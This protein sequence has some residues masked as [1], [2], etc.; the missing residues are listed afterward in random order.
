MKKVVIYILLILGL[1]LMVYRA[2]AGLGAVTALSDYQPWGLVKAVNV[3]TGAALA[4]GSFVVAAMVYVF[5]LRQFRPLVRPA[6]L[7]GFI[8]HSFVLIA[9]LYDVGRPLDVWRILTNPQHH[10]ALMWTAWCEIVY[11]AAMAI[12][13]FSERGMLAKLKVPLVVFSAALAVVYQS[14]LGTLYLAS[15]DAISQL[16]YSD[17]LPA[18]FFLSAVAAG[19]GL[20]AVVSH[21]MELTDRRTLRTLSLLMGGTLV[22]YLMLRAGSL[23]MSGTFT[24][25][26][27]GCGKAQFFWFSAELVIGGAL[28]LVFIVAGLIRD[29]SGELLAAALMCVLGVFMNRMGVTVVGWITPAGHGY[30]P[31]LLEI[32]AS[33]FFV[34]SAALI[35]VYASRRIVKQTA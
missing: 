29:S 4:A 1:A 10:S 11:T 31:S 19:T 24:C 34:F 3:F 17:Y 33:F 28:P 30:F 15:P 32:Y 6:L 13:L 8:G 20:L 16:W 18:L 23:F 35:F 25:V 14:T 27:P 5:G 21:R 22:L 12:E 26:S 7:I 9:L 2:V